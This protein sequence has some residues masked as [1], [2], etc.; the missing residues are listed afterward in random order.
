MEESPPIK[1]DD[2][3]RESSIRKGEVRRENLP[4]GKER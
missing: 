1:G 2:R 3:K 4:S